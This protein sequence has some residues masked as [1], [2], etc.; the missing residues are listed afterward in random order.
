MQ[1]VT[2]EYIGSNTKKHLTYTSFL[3]MYVYHIFRKRME[4]QEDMKIESSCTKRT[5]TEEI[6]TV[7]LTE[8]EFEYQDESEQFS[9]F[10]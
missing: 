2:L 4:K 8:T 9:I 7:A 6:L 3:A 1:P 5:L 10:G